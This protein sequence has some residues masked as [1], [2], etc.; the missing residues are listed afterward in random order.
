MSIFAKKTKV[1]PKPKTKLEIAK[2]IIFRML[3]ITLGALIAAFALEAFLLPNSIIDGGVIGISMMVSHVTKWNLGLIIFVLNLPF[4][5]LALQKM[6]K[7]FVFNVLFG[8]TMLSIFVNLIHFHITDDNLLATV[9]GGMILG[10]G[11]G[12]ILKKRRCA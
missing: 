7:M 9:F 8:V 1:Q 4:L 11:V 3:F 6:G 5:F 12:I 10:A 2:E